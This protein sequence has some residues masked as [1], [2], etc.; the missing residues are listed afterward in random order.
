MAL[1][2]TTFSEL[3][4]R[5]YRMV[6]DYESGTAT[7]GSTTTIVDTTNRLEQDDYWND[8]DAFVWIHSGNAAG[9]WRKVT[10]FA[11]STSTLTIPTASG[12]VAAADTY[13]LHYKFKWDAVKKAIN[14]AI[15]IVAGECLEYEVDESTI[16]LVAGTYE[17]ALPSNCLVLYGVTMADSGGDFDSEDRVSADEYRILKD[18]GGAKLHLIR[19]PADLEFAGHATQNLFADKFTATRKLRLEYLKR[20]TA[21]SALTDTTTIAPMFL[22]YQAAAILHSSK[23]RSDSN[24]P[25]NHRWQMDAMQKLADKERQLVVRT[26]LPMNSKKVFD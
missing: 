24:D 11:N 13:S 8:L 22:T 26:K 9:D 3:I 20:A 5:V 1:Y 14:M 12:A 6:D 21:L 25:E 19:Y 17:Y 15:D 4:E 10:D 7:G 2:S 18:V 23:I 16:T